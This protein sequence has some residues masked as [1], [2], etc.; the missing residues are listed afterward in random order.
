MPDGAEFTFWFDGNGKITLKGRPF[1]NPKANAFSIVQVKDCPYA[2]ETCM[3]VCY[4]HKLE[5]AESG[6]H[7]KYRQNSVSIRRI[8]CNPAYARYAAIAF[9]K[10]AKERCKDGFRW[11]VSGDIFSLEYALFIRHV[12]MLSPEVFFWIYTRSFPFIEP[13]L[14]VSNLVVNLSADKDNWKEAKRTH[15]KYGFRLCYLTVEGEVPPDLPV[16]SVIFPSHELRGRNLLRPTD[17]HWWQTLTK[18]QRQMVCPP[19]FFGQS[20]NLRCGVCKKCLIK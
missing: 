13:L 8:V 5:K 12:C 9:A 19:D 17:V 16:G 18:E 10:W 4:V 1:S 11:H 7:E 6:V 15:E 2:T 20:E 14:G 3:S